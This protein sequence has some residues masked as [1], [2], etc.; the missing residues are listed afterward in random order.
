MAQSK[1]DEDTLRIAYESG[2]LFV[3]YLFSR[4]Q[5]AQIQ[6]FILALGEGE[7]FEEALERIFH[8]D[9]AKAEK[10]LL[11]HIEGKLSS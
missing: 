1:D 7:R 2:Y 6:R 9:Q 10:R 4:Y 8:L 5:R 11:K 3:D